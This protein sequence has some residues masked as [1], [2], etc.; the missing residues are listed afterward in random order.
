VKRLFLLLLLSPAI[1]AS[2][3]SALPVAAGSEPRAIADKAMKY[4]ATNDLNGMFKYI[5]TVMPMDKAELDKIRDT[6]I[7]QRKTLPKTLGE[8]LGY[9]FISECRKSEVVSRVLFLEKRARN[10]I[11][12][13]FV[14]YKP[15]DKW[16]ISAFYW[17][18]KTA[19][20][21]APC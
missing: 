4:L 21:F 19:E 1:F 15:R 17:D 5:Q 3:Q 12:W 10:F 8:Y 16:Q 14:F 6:S 18:T 7:T 13:E 20:I 11:R 9:A 2:S